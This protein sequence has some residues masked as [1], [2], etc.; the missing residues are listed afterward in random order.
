M[1]TL[2]KHSISEFDYLN[3]VEKEKKEA[4]NNQEEQIKK[5]N[6]KMNKLSKKIFNTPDLANTY[7]I[8]ED[9]YNKFILDVAYE[10]NILDNVYTNSLR[11]ILTT[12]MYKKNNAEVRDSLLKF[13]F[14][15]NFRINTNIE[16][17]Q[18]FLK[19]IAEHIENY[20][21]ESDKIFKISGEPLDIVKDPDFGLDPRTTKTSE[22]QFDE[23]IKTQTD[24][25]AARLKS[26]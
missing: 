10:Q 3:D 2:N 22:Q 6:E 9:I 26:L 12:D 24:N 4:D 25:L 13:I 21:I 20:K 18:I 23:K 17:F 5:I 16:S 19:P 11:T 14:D 7:K 8:L 15:S 1:N